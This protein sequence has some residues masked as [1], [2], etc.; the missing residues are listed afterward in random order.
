MSEQLPKSYKKITKRGKTD[1]VYL[2]E[3]FIIYYKDTTQNATI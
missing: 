1:T 3:I 2:K